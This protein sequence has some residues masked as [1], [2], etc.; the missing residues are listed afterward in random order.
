MEDMLLEG[1]KDSPYQTVNGIIVY[2][3]APVAHDD[4][5]VKQMYTANVQNEES[6]KLIMLSSPDPNETAK[7]ASTLKFK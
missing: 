1:M 5:G 7:M 3:S 2:P 6:H 4:V